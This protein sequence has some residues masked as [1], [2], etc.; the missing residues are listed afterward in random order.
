M[1][2]SREAR[3]IATVHLPDRLPLREAVVCL[4]ERLWPRR[5]RNQLLYLTNARTC[6]Q[7]LLPWQRPARPTASSQPVKHQQTRAA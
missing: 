6:A 5:L 4:L 1:V 7:P 2:V 3:S